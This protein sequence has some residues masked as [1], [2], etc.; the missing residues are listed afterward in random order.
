MALIDTQERKR[1]YLA[2]LPKEVTEKTWRNIE[3][4]NTDY[5]TSISDYIPHQEWFTYRQE[6]RDW[7]STDQFPDTR[8]NRPYRETPTGY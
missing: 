5:I 6:L 7:P 2:S 1:K 8:P 4:R 3:L